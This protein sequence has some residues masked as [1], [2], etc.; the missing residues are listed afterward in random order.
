MA[1]HYAARIVPEGYHSNNNVLSENTLFRKSNI[2]QRL[3]EKKDQLLSENLELFL[4]Y[5]IT[6]SI[7][8]QNI[9]D[10]VDCIESPGSISWVITSITLYNN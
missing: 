5:D 7:A 9:K 3:A 4:D 10:W 8:T 1:L 2:E 6:T